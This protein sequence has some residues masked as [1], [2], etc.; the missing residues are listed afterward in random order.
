MK[1]EY[2]NPQCECWCY[3][4]GKL[5]VPNIPGKDVY[6]GDGDNISGGTAQTSARY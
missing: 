3:I 5:C 2:T 1:K 4:G 6:G